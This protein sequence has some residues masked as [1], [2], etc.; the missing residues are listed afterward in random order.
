MGKKKKSSKKAGKGNPEEIMKKDPGIGTLSG[1]SV[2]I[3]LNFSNDVSLS[4]DDLI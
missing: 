4:A 2:K 1:S 3:D